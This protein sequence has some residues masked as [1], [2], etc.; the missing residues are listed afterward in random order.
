M[1]NELIH[2]KNNLIPSNQENT[3]TTWFSEK[4]KEFI[5]QDNDMK[6]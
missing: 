1:L 6:A 5:K 3:I 2:F 4:I